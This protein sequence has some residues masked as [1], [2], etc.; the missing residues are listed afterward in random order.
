[1]F[2]LICGNGTEVGY[3][4]ALLQRVRMCVENPFLL[5]LQT[6]GEEMQR[7]LLILIL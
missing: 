6:M 7:A 4:S 5:K 3:Q 1:M 2:S